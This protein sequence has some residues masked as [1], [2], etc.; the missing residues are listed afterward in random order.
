MMFCFALAYYKIYCVDMFPYFLDD[1][2]HD[3]ATIHPETHSSCHLRLKE[4][5]NL[6]QWN[7]QTSNSLPSCN[8]R[9]SCKNCPSP[10]RS[11]RDDDMGRKIPV[12]KVA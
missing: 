9:A 3:V 11:Q 2:T 4:K 8:H 7:E 5:H 12:T 10:K 6:G 1:V